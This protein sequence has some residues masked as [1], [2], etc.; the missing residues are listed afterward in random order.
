MELP[1]VNQP[2][3]STLVIA[4]QARGLLNADLEWLKL[5]ATLCFDKML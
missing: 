4:K 1:A 5:C 3:D 2:P